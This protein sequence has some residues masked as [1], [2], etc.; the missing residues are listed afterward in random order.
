MLINEE[1]RLANM[2]R[3]HCSMLHTLELVPWKKLLQDLQ[4][5]ATAFLILLIAKHRWLV[6]SG[7]KS[8]WLTTK[9]YPFA[10]RFCMNAL[11][12]LHVSDRLM[13]IVL[14]VQMHTICCS[15]M[16]Y[17]T[18]VCFNCLHT[19]RV[20]LYTARLTCEYIR[21]SISQ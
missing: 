17:V 3:H 10:H 1:L 16:H 8:S 12:M 19:M 7:S 18:L 15:V 21:H 4:L 9:S 20:D 5:H 14:I 6:E 13:M 2:T 11:T